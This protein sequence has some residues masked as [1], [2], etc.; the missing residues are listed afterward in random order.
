MEPRLQP[1]RA[2]LALRGLQPR[3]VQ[4]ALAE[5]PK[6]IHEAHRECQGWR[7]YRR[8]RNCAER[9]E[10]SPRALVHEMAEMYNQPSFSDGRH[11]A[12]A[13]QK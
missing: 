6:S 8:I 13:S 2:V 4:P 7:D 1:A 9:G 10:L 12:D 5:G 11:S 3:R